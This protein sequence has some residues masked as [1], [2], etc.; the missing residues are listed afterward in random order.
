MN[1]SKVPEIDSI[2]ELARSGGMNEA[3]LIEGWVNEKLR[4]S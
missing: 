3:D 1:M 4:A 2:E